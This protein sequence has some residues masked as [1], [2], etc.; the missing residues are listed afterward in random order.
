MAELT[1]SAEFEIRRRISQRGPIPFA[2]FMEVALYWHEDAYYSRA[3]GQEGGPFGP[4][5]DYYTSPMAHPAFGALL[6]VQLYQFWLLLDRPNPFWVIEP[7]SGN[8]QLCRD[9]LQAATSLPARFFD[10]LRYLCVE[11]NH[12]RTLPFLPGAHAISAVELPLRNVRGCV[13]SNELLDSFPVHQVR[14]E[15]GRLREV[16]VALEPDDRSGE[17]RLVEQLGDPSTPFLEARMEELNIQLGEGQTAEINLGLDSWASSVATSL[18][19]GFVLTI[20]Y[21][22]P[23]TEL[24]SAELR[25][26][27]TLVTYYRH[28]QTDSPFR[29]IG[30]QDMTAQ[31][32]FTS[33]VNVGSRAGLE[34]LGYT[35][36]S[37]FL[38]NL[39]F[40]QLRRWLATAQLPVDQ[41]AANRAG[42]LALVRPDGLGNFKVLVQGK[43]LV[44]I[45][46]GLPELWGMAP[47]A[48]AR[49]L[50]GQMP[51]PL[52][53][54][55]HIS[56]P[57]GWS[58]SAE[59]EFNLGDL[60]ANPFGD[61]YEAT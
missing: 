34:T 25:P 30:Q 33:V 27:G 56:L 52:L 46:K 26:R 43:G 38:R 11:R 44:P 18:E 10:S 29:N 9:I 31:V 19:A 48:A 45:A 57:Q 5:G 50:L 21:G 4:G 39:G 59:Q 61:T 37:Q 7:G 35:T 36:Q 1:T 55:S 15:R 53:S 40:D 51:P 47:T 17:E 60:V 54:P 23:A 16:Y 14:V 22:R 24:Y 41:A 32:D 28:T 13:I 8:S 42:L 49:N 3:H 6:S 12:Q 58:Q 20:D 2:E